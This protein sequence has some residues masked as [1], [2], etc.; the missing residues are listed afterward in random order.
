VSLAIHSQLNFLS[1]S[2]YS[3]N[4]RIFCSDLR[5]QTDRRGY[6]NSTA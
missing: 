6:A 1:H 2:S 4:S 5:I 3:G